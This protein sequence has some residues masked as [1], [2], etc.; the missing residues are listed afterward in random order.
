M[1]TNKKISNEELQY[2]IIREA[3]TLLSAKINK[4]EYLTGE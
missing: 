1:T 2:N 3:T 4:C